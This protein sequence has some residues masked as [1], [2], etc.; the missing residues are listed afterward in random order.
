[1]PF[2]KNDTNPNNHNQVTNNNNF[3]QITD[4]NENNEEEN[5]YIPYYYSESPDF[6]GKYSPGIDAAGQFLYENNVI[7]GNQVKSIFSF[8][9]NNL[10]G[11]LFGNINNDQIA[12]GLFD[13][14]PFV[15]PM[16]N[17]GPTK[18]GIFGNI[19]FG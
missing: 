18:G 10:F 2:D 14:L 1:M 3:I 19:T 7:Y 13:P 6:S 15:G 5:N 11:G 17:I 12:N 9:T 8:K 16:E 4:I